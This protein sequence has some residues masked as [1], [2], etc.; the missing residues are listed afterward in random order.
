MQ[1]GDTGGDQITDS[2]R[3]QTNQ[4]LHCASVLSWCRKFD[5]CTVRIP[6]QLLFKFWVIVTLAIFAGVLA[7]TPVKG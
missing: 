6:A 3:G 2:A 5:R 4:V 7:I 1:G